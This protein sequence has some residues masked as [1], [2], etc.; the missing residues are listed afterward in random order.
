MDCI[1]FRNRNR[2]NRTHHASLR[3]LGNNTRGWFGWLNWI[4]MFRRKI[5]VH[6]FIRPSSFS[7][8]HRFIG[9]DQVDSISLVSYF[10][11]VDA[12]VWMTI[13][14]R[15]IIRCAIS[16]ISRWKVF[17]T[18]NYKFTNLKVTTH[19]CKM[20]WS[21]FPSTVFCLWVNICHIFTDELINT[22]LIGVCCV[23]KASPAQ[24]PAK[25]HC[26]IHVSDCRVK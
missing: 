7:L 25:S 1:I 3:K 11:N 16:L 20:K 12:N 2:K 14:P 23:M 24:S 22:K 8:Q 19:G 15:I 13:L 5:F 18:V 17:Y 4:L 10:V 6:T 9:A 26:R 21:F